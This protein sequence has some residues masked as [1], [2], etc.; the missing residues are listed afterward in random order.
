LNGM[1]RDMDETLSLREYYKYC[2]LAVLLGL[3]GSMAGAFASN[4]RFIMAAP[5]SFAKKNFYPEPFQVII[6]AALILS[7][8]AGAWLS[9]HMPF[10]KRFMALMLA[11]SLIP[12]IMNGAIFIAAYHHALPASHFQ[13]TLWHYLPLF[14]AVAAGMFIPAS[15]TLMFKIVPVHWIGYLLGLLFVLEAGAYFI[16]QVFLS[17]FHAVLGP[18]IFIA[19]PVLFT[20]LG[21]AVLLSLKEPEGMETER[22]RSLP[23]GIFLKSCIDILAEDRIFRRFLFA[24]WLTVGQVLAAAFLSVFLLQNSGIPAASLSNNYFFIVIGLILGGTALSG[25]TDIYGPRALLLVSQALGVILVLSA[26]LV[27]P[28]SPQIAIHALLILSGLTIMTNTVSY[29]VMCLFSA[30]THE[31]STY[32]AIAGVIVFPVLLFLAFLAGYFIKTGFLTLQNLYSVALVTM[33][34][35]IGYI[36]FIVENPVG[37]KTRDEEKDREYSFES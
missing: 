13:Y 25:I 24:E 8:L 12:G 1:V 37:F 29:T 32:M 15:F 7:P 5:A 18:D 33:L 35:A 16:L 11:F 4:S 27:T 23:V 14:G 19:V 9:A 22:A 30:P 21:L 28:F 20:L 10:K 2:G 36:Y 6:W 3:S 34:V 31:K 26:R 17:R